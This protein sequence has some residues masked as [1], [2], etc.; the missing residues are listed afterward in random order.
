METKKQIYLF[1]TCL[2]VIIIASV[3][4]IIAPLWSQIKTNSKELL[5]QKT[6]LATVGQDFGALV[7]LNKD[8]LASEK[9]LARVDKLFVDPEAPIDFVEFLEKEAKDSGL[10]LKISSFYFQPDDSAV[11][12]FLGFQVSVAGSFPD[13]LRFLEKLEVSPWLLSFES[14]DVN[15]FSKEETRA[16]L[17]ENVSEGD[18]CLILNL[19]VFT[20]EKS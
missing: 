1:S 12:E 8:L 7:K 3:F 4:L 11:W 19:K 13:A 5:L 2:I 10:G 20:K 6:L 18:V 16:S 17:F 9:D 15:R 14:L